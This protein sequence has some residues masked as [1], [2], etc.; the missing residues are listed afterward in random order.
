MFKRAPS[1]LRRKRGGGI[2]AGPRGEI[3]LLLREPRAM[4]TSVLLHRLRL[5]FR[6][7]LCLAPAG[8]AVESLVRAGFTS[9]DFL[10]GVARQP[11]TWCNEGQDAGQFWTDFIRDTAPVFRLPTIEQLSQ[12]IQPTWQALIDGAKHVDERLTEIIDELP[13]LGIVMATRWGYKRNEAEAK[14]HPGY[15]MCDVHVRM[16]R[17]LTALTMATNSSCLLLK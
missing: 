17:S 11:T 7:A 15:G 8:T 13:L 14:R 9:R 2:P 1:E 3:A 4:E 10:G 16:V 12:F 6:G 5:L